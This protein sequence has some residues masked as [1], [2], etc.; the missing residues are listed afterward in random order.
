ML[1]Q[2]GTLVIETLVVG[3]S[4]SGFQDTL[5]LSSRRNSFDDKRSRL[6]ARGTNDPV[7]GEEITENA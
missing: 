3:L 4:V 1:T 2:S 5:Y 6:E 7:K